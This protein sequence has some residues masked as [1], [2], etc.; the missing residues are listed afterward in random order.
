[1]TISCG[2]QSR[3][4][5]QAIVCPACP[6]FEKALAGDW[7][8]IR[9]INTRP[10]ATVMSFEMTIAAPRSSQRT[11]Y[12]MVLIRPICPLLSRLP[13]P[14]SVSR[15]RVILIVDFPRTVSERAFG[16]HRRCIS[17]VE[18]K[19]FVPLPQSAFMSSALFSH[20]QT[21]R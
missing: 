17:C 3:K 2:T 6:L 1:M 19:G 13:T 9:P 12:S 8:N 5:H 16:S 14:V 18:S 20:T 15:V 7:K 10:K 21:E 4:V 11:N